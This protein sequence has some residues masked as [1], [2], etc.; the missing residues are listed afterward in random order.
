MYDRPGGSPLPLP[1]ASNA[2]QC[3]KTWYYNRARHI[4]LR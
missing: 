3:K 1:K 4:F 2:S